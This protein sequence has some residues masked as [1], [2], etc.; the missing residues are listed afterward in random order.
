VH[1]TRKVTPRVVTVGT[2]LP[3]KDLL[4]AGSRDLAFVSRD[5]GPVSVVDL[6][7]GSLVRDVRLPG[8]R[9]VSA[10]ELSL[11]ESVLFLAGEDGQVHELPL[12]APMSALSSRAVPTLDSAGPYRVVAMRLTAR[13]TMVL[14]T[15]SPARGTYRL[16]EWDRNA[17]TVTAL[18]SG[19]GGPGPIDRSRDGT[20]LTVPAGDRDCSRRWIVSTGALGATTCSIFGQRAVDPAEDRFA[21]RGRLMDGASATERSFGVPAFWG[22]LEYAAAFDPSG[23]TMIMTAKARHTD[24]VSIIRTRVSDGRILGRVKYG[25]FHE[26]VAFSSD[27][28]RVVT[29]GQQGGAYVL[30][31]FLWP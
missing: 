5:F 10:M 28:Q 24:Q 11:D 22:G 9:S 6:A 12:D 3:G 18:P 31:T 15:F 23:A 2:N 26:L 8:D 19:A 16:L 30:S 13:G 1:P 7:A 25:V 17:N 29:V 21:S 27:G 20:R 4:V 14:N